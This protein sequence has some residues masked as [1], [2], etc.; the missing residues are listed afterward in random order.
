MAKEFL[1]IVDESDNV[2]GT[3]DRKIIHEKG[4]LHREVHVYF[5]T[6]KDE[7]I[8]QHRARDKD[9]FPDLLDAT[10]GGH[11]EA[12]DSY[13]QTALKEAFEETGVAIKASN[14]LPIGKYRI[15]FKDEATGKTNHAF[16]QEYAYIFR[17]K[18]EDLKIENGKGLGF[19]AWTREKLLGLS[20]QEKSRFIPYI[21]DFVTVKIYEWLQKQY[22]K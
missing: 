3:E 9:T 11:V 8:F 14:L 22:A 18:L 1:N 5:V 7:I 20:E 19:E 15:E 13:G 2:I 17:G 12:G 21:Y 16:Q 10:V 4:L 6:P